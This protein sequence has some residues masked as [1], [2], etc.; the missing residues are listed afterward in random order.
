MI[1]TSISRF[2]SSFVSNINKTNFFILSLNAVVVGKGNAIA[3][4]NMTSDCFA[5]YRKLSVDPQVEILGNVIEGS[6][7]VYVGLNKTHQKRK[8]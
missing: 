1:Y 8:N 6:S 7:Q 5:Y 4:D 3:Y 2:L